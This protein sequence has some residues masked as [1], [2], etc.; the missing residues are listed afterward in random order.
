MRGL[1]FPSLALLVLCACASRA[2]SV[3]TR[4]L[5]RLSTNRAELEGLVKKFE[6]YRG[7]A[8]QEGSLEHEEEGGR[9]AR[10]FDELFRRPFNPLPGATMP[11]WYD[12][13]YQEG[14]SAFNFGRVGGRDTSRIVIEDIPCVHAV[15]ATRKVWLLSDAVAGQLTNANASYIWFP[16]PFTGAIS[17]FVNHTAGFDNQARAFAMVGNLGVGSQR[18]NLTLEYASRIG[19]SKF[20]RTTFRSVWNAIGLTQYFGKT[21][22]GAT[23]FSTFVD[24]ATNKSLVINF[25]QP[26]VVGQIPLDS[27]NCP[28]ENNAFVG[29]TYQFNLPNNVFLPV[30]RAPAGAFNAHPSCYVD[31]DVNKGFSPALLEYDSVVCGRC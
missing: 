12:R 22:F 27:G 26:E 9:A 28:Q 24:T 23:Y 14:R 18:V 31:G 6:E 17:C 11:M 5:E 4:A 30:E 16:N 25:D 19:G 20:F 1:L 21:R 29:G 10:G 7:I 13:T 2:L 8:R 3:D 15:D